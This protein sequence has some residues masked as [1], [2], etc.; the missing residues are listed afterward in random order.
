MKND[1]AFSGANG[2]SHFLLL[3]LSLVEFLVLLLECSELLAKGLTG[4]AVQLFQVGVIGI[5]L[6]DWFFKKAIGK[7]E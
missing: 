2:G 3:L 5:L 7:T 1:A 6:A 4:N